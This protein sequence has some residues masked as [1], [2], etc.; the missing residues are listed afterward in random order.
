MSP[1]PFE[2]HRQDND[3]PARK[4]LFGRRNTED[5]TPS[6]EVKTTERRGLFGKKKAE[7]TS[8]PSKQVLPTY[9]QSLEAF[10]RSASYTNRKAV[11]Q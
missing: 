3:T 9:L 6:V 10:E 4:P 5:K 2:F 8:S 11:V 7:T 1:R